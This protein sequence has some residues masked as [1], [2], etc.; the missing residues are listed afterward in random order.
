MLRLPPSAGNLEGEGAGQQA[1][2]GQIGVDAGVF[3]GMTDPPRWLDDLSS[4]DR[5]ISV[6]P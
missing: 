4:C 2:A 1:D 6:V 5:R 3:F